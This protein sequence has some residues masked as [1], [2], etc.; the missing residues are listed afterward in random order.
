MIT[1]ARPILPRTVQPLGAAVV[2]L[3][4]VVVF[5]NYV[6]RGNLAT[7]AP[8][9]R[10]E[11]GLSNTQI[12]LLL[13]AFFWSYTPSQLLAGWL[14]ER[15][16]A[17]RT[18]A[19][20]LATWGLAT[21]ASGLANGFAALIALR[22]LLGIG[23]S[24]AFPCSSK[25]LA[26]HLPAHRLGAA[27]GLIGMGL[28]LGPA[29]G[30]YSGGLLMAQVGWRAVFVVFGLASLL[31]LWPW[32]AATRRA[33][34]R[35]NEL[36]SVRAPGFLEI[37]RRRDAWGAALG[38]FSSNYT[39]YF[40]ISWMPLYLVDARGFSVAG[41][42]ELGGLIYVAY[43][44]STML[45]GYLTD[46][47]MRAGGGATLVRK[48]AAVTCHGVVA[49]SMVGCALGDAL[50]SMISLFV[51]AVGFGLNAAGIFAIAQTIAGPRAAGK[52]MGFQN[53]IGNLAGI[54]APLVTGLIVDRTGGF[55]WAFLSAGAISLA[56]ILAWGVVIRRVAPAPWSSEAPPREQI[57]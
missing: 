14:A 46:R 27:N 55:F 3:L 47:W 17:Y 9:M 20:G 49:A 37:L 6:D 34:A 29:F 8:L 32:L 54:V 1:T 35:A 42:A 43:A 10:Q 13:S 48:T 25:L 30:T 45:S 56:G 12:G 50:V 52:W 15:I 38:H 51:A 16:N 44:G 19:I 2:P 39:F 11:L 24:A 57:T 31:W 7:A 40:V 28:A 26:Q 53:C 18:L 41:M 23:E 21:A 33:S 22:L 4:A 36:A 5:I